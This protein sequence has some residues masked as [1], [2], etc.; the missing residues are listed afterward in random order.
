MYTYTYTY[1]IF[2]LDTET[3]TLQNVSLF[4]TPPPGGLWCSAVGLPSLSPPRLG[5]AA[6]SSRSG[7][8]ADP[9]SEGQASHML[10]E[11]KGRETSLIFLHGAT[12]PLDFLCSPKPSPFWSILP[13]QQSL[14]K[15][16][17]LEAQSNPS[18]LTENQKTWLAH[19]L[20]VA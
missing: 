19:P 14:R 9:F 18:F 11:R 20:V 5:L 3:H 7:V 15:L 17:S 13:S 6:R 8:S 12:I 2:V 10:T 16:C 1:K 4:D